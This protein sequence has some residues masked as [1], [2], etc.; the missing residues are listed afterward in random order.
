MTTRVVTA[1][2]PDALAETRDLNAERHDRPRGWV[3]EQELEDYV[4]LEARRDQSTREDLADM[5]AAMVAEHEAIE[6]W[7]AS[8][9]SAKAAKRRKGRCDGSAMRNQ[10]CSGHTNFS[11]M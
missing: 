5:R 7:V 11:R 6:M 9:N 4:F 1:Q 2:I 3:I 10:V 8:L